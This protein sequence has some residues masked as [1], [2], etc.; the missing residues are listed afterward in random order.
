MHGVLARPSDDEALSPTPADRVDC[1]NWATQTRA[2]I[3]A[4]LAVL[5]DARAWPDH[6]SEQLATALLKA[7][8]KFGKTID[9]LA[10]AGLGSLRTRTHG[11]LHLGQVLVAQA[12][13]YFIDFE[14]E[15]ARLLEAPSAK[16]SP[17]RA[18]TPEERRVGKQGGV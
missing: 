1:K 7:R 12:D 4:A 11:D 6:D 18:V 14:V 16:T 17:P 13:A 15:P 2:Q 9:A 5:A 8:G 10:A 3:D